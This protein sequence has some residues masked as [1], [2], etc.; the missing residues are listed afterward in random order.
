[1]RTKILPAVVIST[2]FLLTGCDEIKPF[3]PAAPPTR[4]VPGGVAGTI[5]EYADLVG[6]DYMTVRGVG[7]VVGLGKAGSCDVPD[8]IRKYLIQHMLKRDVGSPTAGTGMLP[9][10]RLL[11]DPDAAVVAVEGRIPPGAPVGTRFDVFV[12]TWPQTQTQTLDGGNL[13]GADLKLS[14]TAS[15]DETSAQTR[16]WGEGHGAIFVNPF[17]DR[18][19]EPAKTRRGRIPNG[20]IVKIER[21][22]RLELRQPDYR[23]A[24]LIQ[25][26]V[27]TRFS[28]DEKVAIARSPVLIEIKI[29][30]VWRD[31]YLHFLQVLSHICLTG[32]PGADEEHARQLARAIELPTARPDDIALVWEAM[33]KH[34]LPM[35]HGLYASPNVQASF[36]SARTGLR[37]EDSLAVE[38]ML[39]IAQQADSPSQLAAI[40]ELGQARR[41]VQVV[42]ALRTLLSD[43]NELVRVAAYE[44]LEAHGSAGSIQR[45]D[46]S[47]QF[48]MDTVQAQ[49]DYVIYA[50]VTGPPRIVLFG[51][52]MPVNL[53][54]FYS[55]AD[56]LVTINAAKTDK[57]LSVYRKVPRSGQMSETFTIQPRVEELTQ[58]LGRLPSMAVDGSIEGM[59]LTYSQVV[60]VL[61]GMCKD[62]HIPA[63]FVL[64]RS[65]EVKRMYLSAAAG[66]RPDSLEEEQDR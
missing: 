59:G 47:G 62:G 66:G 27:N 14:I 20:G 43:S 40:Y 29:P 39:K 2:L 4:V 55:P 65:D 6:G 33:G 51:R 54:I 8:N 16:V 48:T 23:L 28:G 52:G 13:M 46:I 32:G 11:S 19:K 21:P 15:D 50:T 17:I 56:E 7:V 12:E 38:P 22:V 57:D 5:G 44:A 26:R 61:Y 1:M 63:K 3:K 64:Q 25:R 41:F 9:P 18:S 37:L 34:V 58:R 45:T 53:P 10:A 36:F 31:D 60:G 30:R 49:R 35:L 42:P 24:S